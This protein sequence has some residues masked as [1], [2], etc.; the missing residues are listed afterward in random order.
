MAV[1]VRDGLWW[2]NECHAVEGEHIHVAAYCLAGPDAD[3]LVDTGAFHGREAIMDG[4]AHVTDGTGPDAIV[5]SHT[6]Y[7]HAANVGPVCERWP[8]CEV[9]ASTGAPAI[10]GLPADTRTGEV[11]DSVDVHGRELAFVDP[12]LA[13]R[14]HTTWV[15]DP[16]T[17]TLFTADGFGARHAQGACD[18]T[19]AGLGGVPA[20]RV[21]QHHAKT[22][23]WLQYADPDVLFGAVEAVFDE[24]DIEVVAPIHGP[25][26]IGD[27]VAGYL[28]AFRAAVERIHEE[29]DPA[30]GETLN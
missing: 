26:V 29:T 9:V 2:L 22:L 30:A 1:E 25:P 20:E 21:H 17:R 7:P 23:V 13:D 11:G 10:Q 15:Y 12:P 27:D 16:G 4:I 18:A 5:L 14:S 28:S 24:H 6:D 19:S 8:A 3:V